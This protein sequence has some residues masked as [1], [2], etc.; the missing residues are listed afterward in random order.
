[1]ESCQKVPCTEN[2]KCY[3]QSGLE[4]NFWTNFSAQRSEIRPSLARS[5]LWPVEKTISCKMFE[6]W[7]MSL[8]YSFASPKKILWAKATPKQL[9]NGSHDFFHIFS[10]IFNYFLKYETIETHARAFLA[11]NISIVGS[12]VN[13]VVY[14]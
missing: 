10:I 12:V 4:R 13:D 5:Y 7:L 3:A 2:D 9:P 1:M 8:F 6:N 11:L 14:A